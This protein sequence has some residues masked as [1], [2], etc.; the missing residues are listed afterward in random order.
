MKA[1]RRMPSLSSFP[2]PSHGDCAAAW[3]RT[4]RSRRRAIL[5][6]LDDHA[7]VRGGELVI[8]VLIVIIILVL[9]VIVLIVLLQM[10]AVRLQVTSMGRFTRKSS[11]CIA[12]CMHAD[13]ILTGRSLY[14]H[15]M[16]WVAVPFRRVRTDKDSAPHVLLVLSLSIGHS[17]AQQRQC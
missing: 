15:L 13:M 4:H 2:W 12:T 8:I 5:Q 9:L 7:L 11:A 10:P 14:R 6:L 16:F 1:H 17:S 3:Q